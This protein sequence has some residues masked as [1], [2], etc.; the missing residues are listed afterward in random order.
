M[1]YTKAT[2]RII[3]KYKIVFAGPKTAY[4]YKNNKYID[5]LHPVDAIAKTKGWF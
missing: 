2:T 4:L 1:M 3:G 5:T